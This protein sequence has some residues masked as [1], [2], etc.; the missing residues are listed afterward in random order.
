MKCIKFIHCADLHLDTPFVSLE[1]DGNYNGSYALRSKATI[2]RAD[3]KST[4]E[5]I[6]EMS[7]KEKADFIFIC[8]DLYEHNYVRKSTIYFINDVFKSISDTKVIIIPGNHDPW[9]KGSFYRE[10]KWA[11]NVYI[12]AGEKSYLYFEEE[13]V[14]VYSINAFSDALSCRSNFDSELETKCDYPS[15][16]SKSEIDISI[17][18]ELINVLLAHGTV[19]FNIDKNN[20]AS[21]SGEKLE[22]L[23]MDY[24]ALGHF[25]RRNDNIKNFGIIYNPG[26]P[27]PLGFD[28]PGEHGI[29]VG[30]ILKKSFN[31][32]NLDIK[33]IPINKKRYE[34]LKIDVTNC[35]TDESIIDE[36][37]KAIEKI[38]YKSNLPNTI[39]IEDNTIELYDNNNGSIN[40]FMSSLL[41][42][43]VL[44]GYIKPDFNVDVEHIL[45]YFENKL[46]F[47]KIENKTALA[48]DFSEI[49]NEK[50]LRGLFAKKMLCLIEKAQDEHE[51]EL[52]TKSLYYGMQAIDEG[53]INLLFN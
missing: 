28:E 12:L 22:M 7:Q 13:G 30:S 47:L 31:E 44:C 3:L 4:F 19:D 37:S 8:G 29:Y 53:R 25:H 51:K 14:C 10:F 15:C 20:G 38:Y 41:V 21:F 52:L 9:V 36:I 11:E 16:S 17:N 23:G 1:T 2:R 6:A 50:G 35:K 24:V 40:N 18:Y 32:K 39:K 49:K 42:N 26:S 43:I 45:S 34:T 46:F 48:Y 5:K 33:Y 27:E